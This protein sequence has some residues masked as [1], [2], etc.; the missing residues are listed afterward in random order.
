MTMKVPLLRIVAVGEFST[1]ARQFFQTFEQQD[2]ITVTHETNADIFCK[3]LGPTD[4]PS[5]V[6]IDNNPDSKTNFKKISSTQKPIY[7]VWIG[8]T[9]TKDDLIFALESRIYAVIESVKIDEKKITHMF[10]T[11]SQLVA[12]DQ[13]TQQLIRAMKSI[14]LQTEA[15]FPNIPMVDELRNAVKKL[16]NQSLK[17]EFNHLH[18]MEKKEGSD[19]PFHKAQTLEEA[20]V[21]INELQRTGVLWIRGNQNEQEG[22]IEFLQGKITQAHAGSSQNTKAILRMFLWDSPILLFNRRDPSETGVLQSL[23]VDIYQLVKT[24][25]LLKARFEAIRNEIPGEEIF[26]EINPGVI[27]KDT[28]LSTNDFSILASVAEFGRVGTLVDFNDLSDVEIYESLINLR[29]SNMIRK[30]SA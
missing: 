9:F 16:Q 27:G 13:Q 4:S 30:M 12:T 5:V 15:E 17:N 19:I 1:W 3:L 21:I 26:L 8:K 10:Q 7:I 11:L 2:I 23:E 25:S 22:K 14:L 6:F 18:A 24:G 29:R 20:L 28:A